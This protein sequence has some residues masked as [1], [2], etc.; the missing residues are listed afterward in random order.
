MF[1][2]LR[3][4]LPYL[5]AA[6]VALLGVSGTVA[7]IHHKGVL[8]ERERQQNE[9]IAAYLAA[10]M[11]SQAVAQA[12]EADLYKLKVTN[13]KLRKELDNETH[14]DPIYRE[15]ILPVSGVRILQSALANS[16]TSPR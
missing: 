5:I 9:Q 2:F 14:K 13:A 10:V 4:L 7:Y 12:L 1:I 3:P 16:P 11:Q 15:C 6:A 8:A